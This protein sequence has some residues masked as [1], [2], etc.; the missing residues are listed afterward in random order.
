MNQKIEMFKNFAEEYLN[1][2]MGKI[3]DEVSKEK[4]YV[5]KLSL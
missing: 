1:K 3:K 5:E 2:L 4:G